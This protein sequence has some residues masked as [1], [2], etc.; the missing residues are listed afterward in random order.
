MVESEP[1]TDV[2]ATLSRRERQIV[3][4]IARGTSTAEIARTLEI[5]VRTV[6]SHVWNAYRKLGVHNRVDL[7]RMLFEHDAVSGTS[8][9]PSRSGASRSPQ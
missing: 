8:A 9:G 3:V 1:K 5:S 6:E 2:V 4:A 7:V